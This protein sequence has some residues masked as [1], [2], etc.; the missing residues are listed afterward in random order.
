MKYI[1]IGVVV[2]ILAAAVGFYVLGQ[3]DEDSTIIVQKGSD[4]M[5]ELCQYWSED[6]NA[7]SSGI[8]VQ[9][10]DSGSKKPGAPLT[11]HDSGGIIPGLKPQRN[12]AKPA[13]EWNTM[14]VVHRDNK[15]TVMLNGVEV[16][17]LDLSGG[18]ALAQRPKTGPIGFQ[19]HALPLS[20]RQIRIKEL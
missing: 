17:A 5:L 1:A 3:D 19:D 4:T 12:A 14:R 10:Y 11:D 7:D 13:G 8:E 20:L 15:V 16:N 9:I 2:I 18:G 6:F